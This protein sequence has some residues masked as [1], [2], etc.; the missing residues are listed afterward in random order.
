MTYSRVN[1]RA[2]L[3]VGRD[4]RRGRPEMCTGVDAGVPHVPLLA[5]S[6]LLATIPVDGQLFWQ[7][8]PICAALYGNVTHSVVVRRRR[9]DRH[10]KRIWWR[11]LG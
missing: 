8:S 7:R 6:L 10:E 1:Y 5:R 11:I 9:R 3:R 4:H 2:P